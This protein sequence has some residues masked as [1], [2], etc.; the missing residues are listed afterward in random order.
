M[1][2]LIASCR[3]VVG[4]AWQQFVTS[5]VGSCVPEQTQ[6]RLW[7]TAMAKCII[8]FFITIIGGYVDVNCR[9]SS[10]Q[11]RDAPSE[12][13]D[14]NPSLEKTSSNQAKVNN[15]IAEVDDHE[16]NALE[17]KSAADGNNIRLPLLA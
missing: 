3:L 7:L 5:A 15:Q 16:S 14:R 1:R 13:N 10:R 6:N 4:W 11:E 2:I 12:R 9:S 8:S 17:R